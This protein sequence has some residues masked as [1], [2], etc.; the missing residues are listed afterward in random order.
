MAEWISQIW[1]IYIGNQKK[2][3]TDKM[4]NKDGFQKHNPEGK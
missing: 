3:T 2:Q 4:E 1:Y